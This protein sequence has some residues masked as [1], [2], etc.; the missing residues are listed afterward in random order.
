[1][2]QVIK[3]S[4]EDLMMLRNDAESGEAHSVAK[5]IDNL[6]EQ[7]ADGNET[8]SEGTTDDSATSDVEPDLP[9]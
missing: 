3:V 6:L 9:F 2:E 7:N 8:A 1:M 4:V 5:F